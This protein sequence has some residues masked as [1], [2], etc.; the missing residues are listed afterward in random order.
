MVHVRIL[1]QHIKQLLP[2][3]LLLPLLYHVSR[4]VH[5]L[6]QLRSYGACLHLLP[7]P[8]AAIIVDDL[9]KLLGNSK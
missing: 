3:L 1:L 9:S 5:D 6:Q 4:Y 7:E 8:P 2:E